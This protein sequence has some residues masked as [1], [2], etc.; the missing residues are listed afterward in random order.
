MESRRR[1]PGGLVMR[2]LRLAMGFLALASLL[3]VTV[4]A[5]DCGYGPGLGQW[6]CTAGT[7]N[8]SASVSPSNN[9]VTIGVA[10]NG[11]NEGTSASPGGPG[12]VINESPRGPRGASGPSFSL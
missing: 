9:G 8:Q 12:G 6:R 7:A 11:Q 2:Y 5:D 1:I 4:Y 3:P 10:I